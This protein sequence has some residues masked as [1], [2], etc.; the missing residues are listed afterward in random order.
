MTKYPE[1]LAS[2]EKFRN[3]MIDLYPNLE[4]RA[5]IRDLTDILAN[6]IVDEIQNGK[7]ASTDISRYVRGLSINYGYDTNLINECIS[8]WIDTFAEDCVGD[9]NDSVLSIE[10]LR[11]SY[12]DFDISD[13][14]CLTKYRGSDEDVEVSKGT[15]RICDWAFYN[16]KGLN[17]IRIPESVMSIGDY[18]FRCTN[19]KNIIIPNSITNIGKGAFEDCDKLKKY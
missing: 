5:T 6:G 1:C 8:Q 7:N 10:E 2:P 12:P 4:E 3:F 17:S 11:E 15:T 16:F 14:G 9:T 13:D 19:L 18:A